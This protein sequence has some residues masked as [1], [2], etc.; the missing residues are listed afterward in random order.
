MKGQ[1]FREAANTWVENY[2]FQ[3]PYHKGANPSNDDF[4]NPEKLKYGKD[5][6]LAG[7]EHAYPLGYSEA[8]K[9]VREF[10]LNVRRFIELNDKIVHTL[11]ESVELTNLTKAVFKSLASFTDQEQ[12]ELL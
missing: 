9:E 7:C 4:Y 11:E 8:K 1:D 3:I 10:Y 6:F 2:A 12:K 5:G